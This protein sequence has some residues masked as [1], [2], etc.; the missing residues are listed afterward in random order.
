MTIIG[1]VSKEYIIMIRK[2]EEK[3]LT[4]LLDAWYSASKMAH[5]F[6]SEEFFEQE[7]RK[8]ADLH[9]PNSE[10]WVY[11]KDHK[12]VG[13]IS[14]IENEV[15]GIFVD[16]DFHGMGY[17]RELMEQAKSLRPFLELSV[18]KENMIGRSFYE[19]CGF[20]LV[21]EEMHEETG[22]MQLRLKLT[23]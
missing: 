21:S 16:P 3:D 9:I 14:L 1:A 13:F 23:W 8:I 12:V 19:K 10:T 5:S 18:L 15:G 4:E 2:Y 20:K 6:L 11:E 7:R 17:G 22:F